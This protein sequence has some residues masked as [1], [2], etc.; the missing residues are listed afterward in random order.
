MSQHNS[1]VTVVSSDAG[2]G[3]DLSRRSHPPFA[4][5]MTGQVAQ[6]ASLGSISQDAFTRKLLDKAERRRR[7]DNQQNRQEVTV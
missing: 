1:E 3:M 2:Q 5:H 6:L 7:T 4:A